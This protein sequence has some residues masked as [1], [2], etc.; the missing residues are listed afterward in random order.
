MKSGLYRIFQYL[1]FPFIVGSAMWVV[2]LLL[3]IFERNLFS[4][5]PLIILP[6]TYRVVLVL[7][8]I[9]PFKSEWNV[10]KGDLQNRSCAILYYAANCHQGGRNHTAYLALL[11]HCI[12]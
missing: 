4:F 9:M 3:G 12:G 2:V 10:N 5:I 11:A 7:E 1:V 8:R 6:T